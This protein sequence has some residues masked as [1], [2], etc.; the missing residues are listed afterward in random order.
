MKFDSGYFSK[1]LSYF[2]DEKKYLFYLFL[3]TGL[4]DGKFKFL[5]FFFLTFK[6][7][8]RLLFSRYLDASSS[9]NEVNRHLEKG[10][11]LLARGQFG[12]ALSHYHAAIGKMERT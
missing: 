3:I 1:R 2:F 4:V 11:E 8:I 6:L 5:N 7:K 10:M 9:T 12:D